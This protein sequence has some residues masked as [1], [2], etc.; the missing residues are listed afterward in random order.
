MEESLDLELGTDNLDLLKTVKSKKPTKGTKSGKQHQ[1]GTIEEKINLAK[2]ASIKPSAKSNTKGVKA[3]T[4]K[5]AAS[6][7]DTVE[8]KKVPRV[9]VK[10]QRKPDAEEPVEEEND[11]EEE[12]IEED[13]QEIKTEDLDPQ[14]FYHNLRKQFQVDVNNQSSVNI[15]DPRLE[16]RMD[17]ARSESRKEIPVIVTSATIT[18]NKADMSFL[19]ENFAQVKNSISQLI[20]EQHLHIMNAKKICDGIQPH[21]YPSIE[22]NKDAAINE[23]AKKMEKTAQDLESISTLTQNMSALFNTVRRNTDI[24]VSNTQT[25][26]SER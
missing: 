20:E 13:A 2:L 17:Q 25:V 11:E 5:S 10:K 21:S 12:V 18:A 3:T 4:A 16:A 8:H 24:I 1:K 19:V 9:S 14:L 15:T 26:N 23:L 22:D 6:K 7:L